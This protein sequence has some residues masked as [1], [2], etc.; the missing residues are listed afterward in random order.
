MKDRVRW[1]DNHHCRES[2][3]CVSYKQFFDYTLPKF[4][5]IAAEVKDGS[6]ARHTRSADR[7]R[8]RIQK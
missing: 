8:L 7:I 2:Y 5:R 6:A 1:N 3:F 4:M